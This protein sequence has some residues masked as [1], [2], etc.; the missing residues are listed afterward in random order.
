MGEARPTV[1]CPHVPALPRH[2]H[3][4]PQVVTISRAVHARQAAGRTWRGRARSRLSSIARRSAW[5]GSSRRS[6][7]SPGTASTRCR[8]RWACGRQRLR[9]WCWCRRGAVSPSRGTPR[10]RAGYRR[11]SR[12]HRPR[13]ELPGP[14]PRRRSE[15]PRRPVAGGRH[16][17]AIA[18]VTDAGLRNRPREAAACRG[19]SPAF[20]RPQVAEPS[21]SRASPRRQLQ[22]SGRSL[23]SARS[24]GVS[25]RDAPRSHRDGDSADRRSRTRRI[26][27][28][29]KAIEG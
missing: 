15:R 22:C 27:C 1:P 5:C 14:I 7:A 23:W 11:C 26:R 18:Y 2:R 13:A 6:A 4:V 19:R 21:R 3:D 17:V 29:A 16:R 24:R 9:R 20:R 8:R 25:A 10:S 12:S 28:R